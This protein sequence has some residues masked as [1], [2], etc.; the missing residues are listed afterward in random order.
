MCV[1]L[2][3]EYIGRGRG[4]GIVKGTRVEGGVSGL[5]VWDQ[6]KGKGTGVV[7]PGMGKE[8]CIGKHRE[9]TP[10]WIGGVIFCRQVME[11]RSK[12]K[13]VWRGGD[14]ALGWVQY[15][16]MSRPGVQYR[17]VFGVRGGESAGDVPKFDLHGGSTVYFLPVLLT[18]NPPLCAD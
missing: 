16:P 12:E 13:G 3:V 15:I 8:A 10:C 1:G 6:G 11:R 18:S 7:G 2:G 9:G 5:R 17:M 4:G 14:M